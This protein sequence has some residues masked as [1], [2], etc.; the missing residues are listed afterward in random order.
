[1]FQRSLNLE[2]FRLTAIKWFYFVSVFLC[3]VT[4]GSIPFLRVGLARR[5]HGFPKGEAFTSGVFLALALTMMLPSAFTAFR[6]ALP[7]VH[8]PIPSVIALV[9]FL[10]LLAAEHLTNNL[11]NDSTLTSE[12]NTTP[13]IIPVI[14]TAM[15]A[16]PSFFLGAA[17]GLSQGVAA[18]LIF[19]AVILHKGTA[20]F[21]LALTMVRSSLTRRQSVFLLTCFAFSTPLGIVAGVVAGENTITDA[22]LIRAII[23][24]LG[25]G[26]FLY[27]GM[28]HD[29]KRTPLIQH[30][31]S[32]TCFLWMLA[33]LL[34]TALVRW[35]IGESHNF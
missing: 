4:G 15:I 5:S 10:M 8:Y 33:G 17:L 20:A 28:L 1:M 9:A 23:L 32:L 6:Q 13:A 22:V 31:C 35:V 7:T 29:L 27:M 12:E 11:A 30:C 16:T 26:T 24:S 2:N 18:F 34:I 3:V 21:A 19:A 25:T 14:L